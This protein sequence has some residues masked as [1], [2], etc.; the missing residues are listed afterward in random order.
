MSRAEK[1]A[2]LLAVV[3]PFVAHDRRDRA[4]VEPGGRLDRSRDPR[5]HVPVTAFGITIGYHRLLTHRA[6]ETPRP[7]RYALA[8]TGSMAV[9]GSV[10]AWVA[11]HRKHHAFSDDE[12][13][14][15]SPHGH[16]RAPRA[17]SRASGTPTSAG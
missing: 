14:P 8:V 12:G 1:V 11:D 5:R 16:G 3:I 7:M 17:C 4:P 2:N 13:D 6:F 9:Q 15:H 10:I